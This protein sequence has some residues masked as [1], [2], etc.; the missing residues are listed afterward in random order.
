LEVYCADTPEPLIV[1][2]FGP[3]IVHEAAE[4]F[5]ETFIVPLPGES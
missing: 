1:A 4:I 2:E 5:E 3:V